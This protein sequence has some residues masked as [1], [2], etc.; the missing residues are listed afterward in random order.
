[1]III[2]ILSIRYFFIYTLNIIMQKDFII[3]LFHSENQSTSN[4]L[5]SFKGGIRPKFINEAKSIFSQ[6]RNLSQKDTQEK[7]GVNEKEA[8][9]IYNLHQEHGTKLYR[10]IE[11][12]DNDFYKNLKFNEKDFPFMDEHILIIDP[13][14]GI[15]KPSDLISP[16]Y[17]N[18]NFQN[19][20]NNLLE[21]WLPKIQEELKGRKI[22]SFL[23]SDFEKNIK[24]VDFIK[25]L[26]RDDEKLKAIIVNKIIQKGE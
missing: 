19:L 9:N 5:N 20:N 1:M 22:Y 16:Y 25:V 24:N 23:P 15:V 26:N 21:F 10:A 8:K 11:I 3:L 17:L 14:Y 2:L 6:I 12:Y 7:Y 13:L 18:F 4:V